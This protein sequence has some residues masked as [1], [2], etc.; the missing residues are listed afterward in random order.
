MPVIFLNADL[1]ILSHQ[2]LQ[3][4]IDEIGNRAFLLACGPSSEENTCF[5]RYELSLEPHDRSPESFLLAFTHLIDSLSP[6]SL[7]L[8]H[9][10][11][12]RVI[13]IGYQCL[14]SND[15]SSDRISSPTLARLA[16]LHIDLA[17]SFYPPDEDP[18]HVP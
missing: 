10:A 15:R 6:A 5:A 8:W 7:S 9:G 17:W 18:P 13:D 4:L 3:P 16:S 14:H 2:N 11:R 12:Q 1:D